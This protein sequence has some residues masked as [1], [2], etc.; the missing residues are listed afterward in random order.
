MDFWVFLGV[1]SFSSVNCQIWGME[2]WIW[3]FVWVSARFSSHFGVFGGVW[4][5]FSGLVYCRFWLLFWFSFGFLQSILGLFGCLFLLGGVLLGFAGFYCR[6]SAVWVICCCFCVFLYVS[7]KFC[8]SSSFILVLLLNTAYFL[9]FWV[10]YLRMLFLYFLLLFGYFGC[11]VSYLLLS[12][13]HCLV[14]DLV[15]VFL[16]ASVGLNLGLF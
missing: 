2:G 15:W 14:F 3:G 7:F 6:F 11:F 5:C 12:C 13:D 10:V 16:F 1:F 9:L 4:W 8:I